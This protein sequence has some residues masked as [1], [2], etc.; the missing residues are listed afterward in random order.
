MSPIQVL[1]LLCPNVDCGQT[2][3]CLRYDKLFTCAHC[4]TAFRIKDGTLHPHAITF[5]ALRSAAENPLL[6]FPFWKL[7]V[8][9]VTKAAHEKQENMM[10][11]LGQI[12]I[13]WITGF[14]MRRPDFHGDLG[15]LMSEKQIDIPR[16]DQP[17]PGVVV[18]GISRDPAEAVRYGEI[19]VT[20]MLDKRT[21]VTGMDIRV[22]VNNIALWA[23]PFEDQGDTVIDLTTNT[24]LPS[25]AIDDLAE[26]RKAHRAL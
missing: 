20:A 26:I 12:H 3:T 25:N 4:K 18:T 2:L 6:Y 22:K 5:A 23:L 10:G 14:S 16:A 8:D 24:R 9:V 21:D 1:P 15:M 13:L 19:F 7:S 11:G 17:P